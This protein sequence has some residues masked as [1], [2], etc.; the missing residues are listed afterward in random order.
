MEK[1]F[2]EYKRGDEFS[3]YICIS[4]NGSEITF[5]NFKFPATATEAVREAFLEEAEVAAIAK[6][7]KTNGAV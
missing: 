7:E 1:K 5:Q 6:L 2:F 4:L 3:C